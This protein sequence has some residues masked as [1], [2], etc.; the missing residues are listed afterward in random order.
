[1][2]KFIALLLALAMAM[3]LVACGGGAASTP[4]ASNGGDKS[5]STSAPADAS[6]SAS[7]PDTK[8]GD[9]ESPVAGKKIAYSFSLSLWGS[10]SGKRVRPSFFL[11]VSFFS[12]ILQVLHCSVCCF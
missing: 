11:L 9:T 12:L 7:T 2:K 10:P 6:G 4:A 8:G 3:S 5:A 1:M